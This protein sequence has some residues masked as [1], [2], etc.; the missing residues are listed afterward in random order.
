MPA[1]PKVLIVGG[2]FGGVKAGLSLSEDDHYDITLL[3]NRLDLNYYPTL[4]RTAT[5][6]SKANSSIPLSSIFAHTDVAVKEGEAKT[7]DRKNKTIT[8]SSGDVYP[9]DYLILALGVVTNYFNIPGLSEYSYGIKSQEEI[10]RFK[11]HIHQQLT[12]DHRPDLN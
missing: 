5:G 2:G 4:Y 10:K 12:D 9:Y 6:S 1:K 3:S 7:I 11:D 8:T